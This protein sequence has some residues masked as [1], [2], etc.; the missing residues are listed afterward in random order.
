MAEYPCLFSEPTQEIEC[1]CADNKPCDIHIDD[2]GNLV[3]RNG[4][5]EG[6]V[7]GLAIV[8][9]PLEILNE[10]KKWEN[11]LNEEISRPKYTQIDTF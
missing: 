7:N 6:I 5:N 1:L 3:C 2:G 10:G 11:F 4:N 9:C 8:Q